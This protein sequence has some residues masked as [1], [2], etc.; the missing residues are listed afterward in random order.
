LLSVSLVR[1]EDGIRDA[2]VTGV[3]TC[4]LPIF[5]TLG[6]VLYPRVLGAPLSDHLRRRSQGVARCL[7]RAGVALHT[8][9][10][11]PQAVAGP[12]PP[13]DFAAEASETARASRHIPVLLPSMGVLIDA[14]LPRARELHERLPEEPPTFTHA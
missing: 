13:H 14:L 12:L 4:A 11:L 6:V 2:T 1:G 9:H 3:Q 10:R 5:P 7:E 8:L